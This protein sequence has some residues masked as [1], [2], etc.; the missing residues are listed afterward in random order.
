MPFVEKENIEFDMTYNNPPAKQD[1][2]KNGKHIV[3]KQG[4]Y[5][6]TH[7]WDI[8][9]IVLNPNWINK[10]TNSKKT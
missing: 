3:Q 7:Y 1:M 9:E 10:Q 4:P 6:T 8:I 5:S 2:R